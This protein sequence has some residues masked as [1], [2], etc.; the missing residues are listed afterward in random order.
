MSKEGTVD[1][2]GTYEEVLCDTYLLL[3]AIYL[4]AKE[5]GDDPRDVFCDLFLLL[6]DETA[7]KSQM[8]ADGFHGDIRDAL[9]KALTV[10]FVTNK[11]DMDC[12]E[13]KV[14]S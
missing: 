12:E 14:Y 10:M 13:R 9:A 2:N 11:D 4:E 8:E 7:P 6:M 3:A 1:V 5:K